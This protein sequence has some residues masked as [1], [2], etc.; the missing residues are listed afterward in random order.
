[1]TAYNK[2]RRERDFNEGEMEKAQAKAD[3]ERAGWVY[4]KGTITWSNPA[5]PGLTFVG[6]AIHIPEEYRRS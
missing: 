3:A 6:N 1:M 4:D 2:R 5:H